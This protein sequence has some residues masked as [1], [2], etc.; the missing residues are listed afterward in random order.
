MLWKCGHKDNYDSG[1]FLLCLFILSAT[2]IRCNEGRIER[3]V[4][5]AFYH[6]KSAVRLTPY[7]QQ[8]LNSLQVNTIYVK[9]FDVD[10]DN[11]I[12]QPVPV[13]KLATTGNEQLNNYRVIP[14]IFITNNCILEIDSLQVISLSEK[15]V[16]LVKDICNLAH[17]NHISEIQIDCD[18]TSSTKDKYFLILQNIKR[19]MPGKNLS[20]TIRLHQVKYVSKSGIP[21][22]DR[23]LLMCY[24]MGN[25]KNP[26]TNNSII[27]TAELKKYIDQLAAYPLNLDVAFP[28]FE[29]RVLFRNN[30]FA[31]LVASIDQQQ[32]KP[33][34]TKQS[35]NRVEILKDT[36]LNGYKLQKGDIL[37]MEQSNIKEVL[38]AASEIN[39]HLKNHNL[40]VALYHLDSVTLSKYN[41]HEMESIYN[42]FH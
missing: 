2:F 12:R 15:I 39:K 21:P 14:T 42:S 41:T 19:L 27:E 6:W 3:K 9:F 11:T 24:N 33:S 34:F 13:A 17:I 23:G 36:L 32:L 35:G 37:R 38:S 4:E 29:W 18:W 8:A 16:G 20:A 40:R 5:R 22:I 26:A 31:G 10:W 7:E 30:V 28:L 25:L 1:S